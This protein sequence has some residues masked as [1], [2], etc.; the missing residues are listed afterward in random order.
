MSW[1]DRILLLF[2]DSRDRD[3]GSGLERFQKA[4]EHNDPDVRQPFSMRH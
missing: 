4:C 3:D 1:I 2:P